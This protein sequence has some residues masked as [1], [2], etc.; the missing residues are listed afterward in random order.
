M[1]FVRPAALIACALACLAW[2]SAPSR[3]L[4]VPPFTGNDTG[5]IIAWAY[6]ATVDARVLANNHCA[7]YGKLMR[8]LSA[9]RN[10]GG[11]I[12]F[13]CVWPRRGQR[14]VVLE[15]G[16]P[17]HLARTRTARQTRYDGL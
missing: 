10:Y 12:S 11:Y 1:M 15:P 16:A 6:A 17:R 2:S 13:A 4:D 9:Q 7:S 3:A 8:P 5:G 14:V